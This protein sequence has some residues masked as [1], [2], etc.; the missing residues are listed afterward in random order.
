LYLPTGEISD[1]LVYQIA[2]DANE[3]GRPLVV[4]TLSDCDPSG[5]QMP[6]SIGRKLQA[7]KDLLFPNLEFEMVPIAVMPDQVRDYDLPEE[8]LKSSDRRA[9]AWKE[10][11]GVDQTEIDCL[12]TP[13]MQQR[14]LLREIVEAAVMF[15]WA[16]AEGRI[17]TDPAAGVTREKVRVCGLVDYFSR[18]RGATEWA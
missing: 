3:D 1:T 13:E 16:R 14:G 18:G 12:T 9:E 17:P 10:E 2:K 15:K 6:V 8:P 7:F 11:F 5:W 4:F